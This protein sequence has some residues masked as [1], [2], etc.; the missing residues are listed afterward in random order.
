MSASTL[1]RTTPLPP[2]P[3]AARRRARGLALRRT[4]TS[5]T[6]LAPALVLFGVFMLYPLY[7]AV[8]ISLTDSTGIGTANFTGL[9]NYTELFADATFW[10][11]AIN[12]VVLAAVSVPISLA[13]GLG[14]ALLLRDR[15][16]A[17]GFFRALFLAPYVL[18]G[19]VVAMLGRWLFDQ[20]VGV[21]NQILGL[22]GLGPVNWQSSPVPAAV[23]VFVMM[24]WWRTGLAV[25]IYLSALQGVDGDVLEAAE[26]DGAN[27]WQRLR[28][29]VWPLLRPTTFFLTVL[30]VIDTFQVFD[31]VFVMTGGGPRNATELLVTYAYAQGFTARREGYG[32]AVGVVVFLVVL[33]ATVLWYR[34][35]RKAEE[36]L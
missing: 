12:T 13:L 2:P 17:R 20:N 7:G 5:Y 21:T 29:V 31:L 10:R 28:L 30:L 25:I 15:L 1:D 22:V 18:S 16:P 32:S 33:L 26:L 35:Q 3:T 27:A 9:R 23:S 24:L 4:A 36:F 19:V 6:M 14:V 11:A 34:S 8:R